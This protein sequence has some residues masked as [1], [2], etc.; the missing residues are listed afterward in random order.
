MPSIYKA[1]MTRTIAEINER[2]KKGDAVVLTA[3][4]VCDKVTD[5]EELAL[6]DVDVVTTATRAIMSGTYAVLSFPMAEAGT[7]VRAEKA[8]INGVP[9]CIGPCPNERLGIV[10]LMVYGTAHS[11]DRADYGGGHLFRDL[12]AGREVQVEVETSEGE[13]LTNSICLDE[14]P[15]ARIFSTRNAFKNYVAFVNPRNA[16]LPTIF[17][18]IEFPP[19]LSCATVSG[20]GSLNPIKNDPNLETIGIG[21][22]ILLNGAEGFV[23]GT[24]TRSMPSRPN[25]LG[26]ADM[27]QMSPEYMGGFITSAGPECIGSWAVPI[28][29]LNE[30]ILESILLQDRDIALTI[31]DVNVRQKIGRS[32]YED[33]WGST[34]LEIEFDPGKCASC[35]KCTAEPKCPMRAITIMEDQVKRDKGKCFNCGL[36]ASQCTGGA[37]RGNLGAIRLEGSMIPIQLRQSDRARAVQLA[38]KLKMQILD[39]SFRMTQMVEHL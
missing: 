14:I 3:Q 8:R 6:K 26:L 32:N 24:G 37:F 29:V 39:G 23:I 11:K 12:V 33:V 2:I 1:E 15:Y 10:D 7:F 35:R 34:D 13:S 4:E 20:C 28:P 22:R 16:P 27:H 21:T 5:G 31:M 9:A 30:S 36:C 25:L 17:S 19:D 38:K 18:A